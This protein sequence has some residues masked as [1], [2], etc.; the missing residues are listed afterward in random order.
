[1][2]DT[3]PA[4][5]FPPGEYLRDEL[6]ERGWDCAALAAR[7]GLSVLEVTAILNGSQP[8]LVRTAEKLERA[9]GTSAVM[10]LRLQKY[11][12]KYKDRG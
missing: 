7:T 3:Q 10:W 8:I 1:M 4:E 2:S 12:E 5:V 9:L 11:Y 6:D